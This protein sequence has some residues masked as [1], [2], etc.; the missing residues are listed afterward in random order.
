[1]SCKES[2]FPFG[3]EVRKGCLFGYESLL[4]F[5][6]I[7]CVDKLQ[8]DLMYKLPSETRVSTGIHLGNIEGFGT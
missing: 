8:R 6:Q 1:M 5:L 3:L 7:D 4:I 2:V